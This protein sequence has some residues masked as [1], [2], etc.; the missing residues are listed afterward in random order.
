VGRST[1]VQSARHVASTRRSFGYGHASERRRQGSF[2]VI[3]QARYLAVPVTISVIRS[4]MVAI[5]REHGLCDRCVAD[6]RLAVS[7]AATNVI[8]HAYR[9]TDA[10]EITATA[11]K[12]DGRLR[13]MISDQGTGPAPRVDSPGLG[14][15]LPIIAQ[16]ADSVE[17]IAKDV[18][19]EIRMTFRCRRPPT[20]RPRPSAPGG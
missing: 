3:W 15:G 7:E 20:R 13:I 8:Q 2:A 18:G 16:L 11:H 4:E 1:L 14:L 19:T 10:G 6:V 9:D 12:D 17:V 5:A